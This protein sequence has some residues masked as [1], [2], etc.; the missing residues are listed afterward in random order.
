MYLFWLKFE[1]VV[2]IL[3]LFK[4][5]FWLVGFS[6]LRY[7]WLLLILI[8]YFEFKRCVL[9]NLL[10]NG[11]NKIV[12]L[13][14]LFE[15]LIYKIVFEWGGKIVD[16]VIFVILLF[17]FSMKILVVLLRKDIVLFVKFMVILC[18]F[19]KFRL[20]IKEC[21]NFLI[22]CIGKLNVVFWNDKGRLSLFIIFNLL[23]IS[24]IK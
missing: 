17:D 22:I 24:F 20:I 21:G 15:I 11:F 4:W 19:M 10:F 14:F 16:F 6:I 7:D 9:C 12:F 23:L 18:F 3:F 5:I 2:I 1:I 13:D 8:K